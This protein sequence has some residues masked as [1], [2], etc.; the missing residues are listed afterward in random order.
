MLM[1]VLL[2]VAATL[3]AALII[4]ADEICGFVMMLMGQDG[5]W[6][7]N[8]EIVYGAQPKN[9]LPGPRRPGEWWRDAAARNMAHT[10]SFCTPDALKKKREETFRKYVQ[11]AGQPLLDAHQR[12]TEVCAKAGLM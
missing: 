2:V 6:V 9:W 3:I 7:E 11:R 10:N 8:H 12:W 5:R 4:S 1:F